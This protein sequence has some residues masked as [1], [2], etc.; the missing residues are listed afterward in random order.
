M[1]TQH[2]ARDDSGLSLARRKDATC[3]LIW[4]MS[5]IP[6]TTNQAC[7]QNVE[8]VK[9]LEKR[10]S[11]VILNVYQS[12]GIEKD[13]GSRQSLENHAKLNDIRWFSNKEV[14]ESHDVHPSLA[15]AEDYS[16][17]TKRGEYQ[18]VS[19]VIGIAYSPFL[20]SEAG[21]AYMNFEVTELLKLWT[22]K[23]IEID[24]YERQKPSLALLLEKVH[25]VI[26]VPRSE[27]K[28]ELRL[29]GK[30]GT[31]STNFGTAWGW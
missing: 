29:G 10:V 23:I 11:T 25:E 3:F 21:A 2:F 26:C 16:R 9:A 5:V 22:E 12:A 19:S 27:R 17:P 7:Y 24:P 31:L 20:D 14:D 8:G 6:D 18:Y 4:I 13:N 1:L 28:V 15:L 30:D